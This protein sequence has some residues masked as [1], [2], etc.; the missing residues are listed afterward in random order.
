[1]TALDSMKYGIRQPEI[2]E[3]PLSAEELAILARLIMW[4]DV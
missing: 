2:D 4:G 1:M 3:T